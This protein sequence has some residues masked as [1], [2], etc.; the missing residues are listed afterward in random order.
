MTALQMQWRILPE[1][2]DEVIQIKPQC[3]RIRIID[4]MCRC[5]SRCGVYSCCVSWRIFLIASPVQVEQYKVFTAAKRKGVAADPLAL[6]ADPADAVHE[7]VSMAGNGF[8]MRWAFLLAACWC[9]SLTHI[10]WPSPGCRY[11]YAGVS[12]AQLGHLKN[13]FILGGA[14][15]LLFL[16][17]C[18][19]ALCARE[20]ALMHRGAG[21]DAQVFVVLTG[22][23][24]KSM[25]MKLENSPDNFE[26]GRTDAFMLE[27]PDLGDV[28][29][30]MVGHNGKGSKPRWHLEKV[31]LAVRPENTSTY[32]WQPLTTPVQ[33]K[34]M[35]QTKALVQTKTLVQIRA[36]VQTKALVQ[37]RAPVQTK[38]LMQ[39]RVLVQTK[40]L[41]MCTEGK[42]QE[43]RQTAHLMLPPICE[44]QASSGVL[45]NLSISFA[46]AAPAWSQSMEYAVKIPSWK[47]GPAMHATGNLLMSPCLSQ[48]AGTDAI[49][50]LTM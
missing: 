34:V 7:S 17:C 42:I 22:S 15:H 46:L 40:V 48:G 14:I 29:T 1:S 2:Q 33:T 44:I 27:I 16:T 3:V 31:S 28:H 39:L 43:S 49:V 50:F 26:R 9:Q 30:V 45:E 32:H 35:V 8:S 5:M 37:I 10:E 4:R 21:T 18:G 20:Q 23:K 47:T 41:G 36:P 13:M 38:A 6:M 24:G 12:G 25:D 11:G 19:C